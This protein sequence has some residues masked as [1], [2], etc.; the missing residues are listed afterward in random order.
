[1]EFI[2]ILLLIII[3]FL[4]NSLKSKMDT[5]ISGLSQKLD[6]IKNELQ[7]LKTERANNPVEKNPGLSKPIVQAETTKPA[8]IPIPEPIGEKPK[9]ITTPAPNLSNQRPPVAPQYLP[10][11]KENKKS[12]FERYPDIEN[13]IGENLINKIGIAILVLG[14]GFFVKYA[15]DQ[16]WINEVG[17]VAIGI[18]CGGVLVAIAHKMRKDYK[19]F[20]SVLIGGGMAIFYFT[21]AIAFHEYQLFSQTAAFIIMIFITAFSIIFALLYDRIELAVVAIVGGFASPFM[22]S[23]GEG[24]YIV[25][26][27][28]ILI[29]N[30]GMLILAYY[31]KWNLINWISYGFTVLLFGGWL[32][33]KVL[34]QTNAPYQGALIFATIFYFVFFLMNIINNIKEKRKFQAA[35][36]SILVSNTFLYFTAGM[37]ILGNIDEGIYRGLFTI[38]LAAF[39]FVFAFTLL[40]SQ[41]ADT[42][43]V[44]LLIGMVLTFVSLA[45]PVQLEGNYIT[46]FWATETVLLL[47]LSQKSGIR[48]IKAGSVIIMVLMVISLVMDWKNIYSLEPTLS[49]LIN[50][51]FITSFISLISILATLRLLKNEPP[52][53]FI[54]N[55]L[56]IYK[57]ALLIV[58]SILLYTAGLLELQYQ[59]NLRLEVSSL[60]DI[61]I[62]SYNL[63]FILGIII[64]S[65]VQSREIIKKIAVAF[66]IIGGLS[67]ILYYNFR[68]VALRNDYLIDNII[69]VNG[70]LYHYMLSLLTL[71]IAGLSIRSLIK[72]FGFK[73]IQFK[74]GIWFYIFTILFILST[75]LDHVV[76]LSNYTTGDSSAY[77]L[78]QNR[79]IGYAILWGLCSF[80]L[81]IMGMNKKIKELRI[82]SLT[83]FTITL[84]KLFLLDIRGI[85]EG[86]KIASFICLGILLL[87]ISFMYQKLKKLVTED[88]PKPTEL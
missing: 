86:G 22:V 36:I 11:P 62:G 58:F 87:S 74:A 44:Y 88:E 45:A 50:K 28:Y 61:V 18:L 63:T 72:V 29:L 57:N 46:L 7:I 38:L 16:D 82:I 60:V 81:M 51:G 79:K 37:L 13:F 40:K 77:I 3:L 27:S 10:K 75:E 26:F 70:Y 14:I 21:I 12:F 30:I 48:V 6:T 42:N 55:D 35:E 25:L 85:S 69:S 15:I 43:L 33:L 80:A 9:E 24:N 76:L 8:P 56:I 19:P 59:A 49:I 23:T 54:Q 71:A 32:S 34:G 5:R 78:T 68:I 66:G 65:V 1:M 47:W 64:W 17:R 83:L 2:S 52:V 53:I 84:L 73:S 4:L 31:K 41:K 39:N 20:S 67:F